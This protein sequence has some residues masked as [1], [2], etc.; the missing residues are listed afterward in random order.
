MIKESLLK[1]NKK[2]YTVV[3]GDTLSG[4]AGKF[5]GDVHMWPL[6]IY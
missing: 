3:S 1:E 2:Q 4:I 5:Y 6:N